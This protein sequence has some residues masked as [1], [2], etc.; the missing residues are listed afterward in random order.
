MATAVYRIT[1]NEVIAISQADHPFDQADTNYFG[2]ISG[3]T[4]PDGYDR[5]DPDGNERVLGY[6]KIVDGTSVRNATQEE[7]D[8]FEGF[9]TADENLMDKAR[10]QD[11]F[12]THPQFRK[13]M[14][15]FADI[16]KDEFN[17]VR[18]RITTIQNAAVGADNFG[19]FKLAMLALSDLNDRTLAQLKTAIKNRMSEND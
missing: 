19:E 7:I 16:L 4:Y 9:E 8:T 14:I 11:L 10:A 1:S 18:E 5:F 3:A 2:V 15:A 17:I 13:M 6:A 12:E